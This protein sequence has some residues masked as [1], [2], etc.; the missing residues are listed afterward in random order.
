MSKNVTERDATLALAEAM[1]GR[2]FLHDRLGAGQLNSSSFASE[3]RRLDEAAEAALN[4]GANYRAAKAV[5][6][7]D[8]VNEDA[9]D[10]ALADNESEA[11]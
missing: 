4:A 3:W 9:L 6:K 10:A 7:F 8:W 5:T 11:V 1:V 2:R